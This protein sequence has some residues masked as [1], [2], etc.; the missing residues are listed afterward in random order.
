MLCTEG[1]AG[2]TDCVVPP[3]GVW[4]LFVTVELDGCTCKVVV[5]V[6]VGAATGVEAA[7]VLVLFIVV[8]VA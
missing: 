2:S 8:G 1:R 7:V 3:T 5:L 6:V 4:V